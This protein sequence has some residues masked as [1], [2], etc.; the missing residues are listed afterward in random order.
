M[1]KLLKMFLLIIVAGCLTSICH[2]ESNSKVVA[3]YFHGNFRCATCHGIE[4][5]TKEAIDNNFQKELKSGQLEFKAV[6]TEKP[7]NRHYVKDYNLYTKSVVLSLVKNGKEVKFKNLE[8][9][10]EYVR[11]KK[12]FESYIQK[13][14]TAYLKEI[15]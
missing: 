6:N 11:N 10:W 7:K 13:E 14:T 12:K 1:D 5:Y 2:A 3:Y 8:K 9:V 4:N 15:E